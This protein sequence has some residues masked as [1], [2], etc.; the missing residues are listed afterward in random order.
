MNEKGVICKLKWMWLEQ[1][2]TLLQ[3]RTLFSLLPNYLKL[4][5]YDK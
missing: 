2:V 3:L 5:P 1:D 4:Q